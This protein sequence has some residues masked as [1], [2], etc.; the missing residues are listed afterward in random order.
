MC[1][2]CAQTLSSLFLWHLNKSSLF[3][4]SYGWKKVKISDDMLPHFI[5]LAYVSPYLF[6]QNAL[7]SPVVMDYLEMIKIV[8]LH[9]QRTVL[10]GHLIKITLIKNL[11]NSFA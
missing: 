1:D 2:N 9:C 3:I 10:V 6:N 7:E 5:Y 8:R 11:K 4:M